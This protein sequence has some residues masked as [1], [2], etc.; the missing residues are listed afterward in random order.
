MRKRKKSAVC[1]NCNHTFDGF[2]NFCPNCGQ[3]NHTHKLPIKHFLLEF[4]ES[5]THFDAKVF[6]TLKEMVLKPGVVVRNYND[7]MRA[8]Y[9]PPARIY[10]FMSFIFFLL[11]SVLYN[12]QIRKNTKKMESE[13]HGEYVKNKMS[14]GQISV[15][16][17]T[18]IDSTV[19]RDLIGLKPLSNNAIDSLFKAK[20][21]QTDWINN[22]IVH[23]I[24]K[25]TKGET[26]VEEMYLKFIKYISYSILI[27]MPFFALILFLFYLKQKR[28]YSEYL[29]FSIYFHTFIFA[30]L[31]LYVL[32]AKYFQTGQTG[33][34]IVFMIF[35]FYLVQSLKTAFQQ[36]F[37]K[38]F[39]KS[40]LISLIYTISLSV[41]ALSIL[42]VTFL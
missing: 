24:I 15:F 9:V 37:F 27:L 13:I 31:I 22:R 21:I 4:I 28:Y 30:V 35:F 11:V 39:L 33:V 26:S 8:R 42:L 1:A 14:F 34:F 19:F 7:N 36:S 5:L 29:V 38:S 25:V 6:L 2:S 16:H 40:L 23:T 32:M 20:G 10:I 18:K 3:E 41:L 17:K 12:Q